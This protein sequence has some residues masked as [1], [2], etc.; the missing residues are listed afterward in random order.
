MRI[1]AGAHPVD[2][3]TIF[4]TRAEA[5]ELRDALDDLLGLEP[6][7]PWHAHVSSADYLTEVTIAAHEDAE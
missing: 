6:G 4:L 3:V 1:D 5:S 2:S 7:Q